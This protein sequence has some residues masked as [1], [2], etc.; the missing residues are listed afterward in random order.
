VAP[1]PLRPPKRVSLAQL[2]E[3]RSEYDD[4]WRV[5]GGNLRG[6]VV[7]VKPEG[8]DAGNQGRIA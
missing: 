8:V 1:P 2:S 5:T 6:L 4:D 7:R 3:A